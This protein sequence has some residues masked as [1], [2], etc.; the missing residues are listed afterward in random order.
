MEQFLKSLGSRQQK[1]QGLG[2]QKQI[3]LGQDELDTYVGNLSEDIIESD[4]S[5]L[6]GLRTTNYLHDNSDV[7]I[8]LSENTGE[9]RSF[10][11][12]KVPGHVS[13]DELLKLHEIGCE[14]KMLVIE[15]SENSA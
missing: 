3:I 6:F 15:K 14:G 9:K 13:D 2:N 7:Q 11:Y 4:L 8:P 12:V 5:E 10:A 1:Q